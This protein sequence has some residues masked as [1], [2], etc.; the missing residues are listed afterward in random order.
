[1]GDRAP[2]KMNIDPML[3]EVDVQQQPN[4]GMQ[5]TVYEYRWVILILA[6]VVVLLALGIYAYITRDG[7][8]VRR[9]VPPRP[10]QKQP[11]DEKTLM[12]AKAALLKTAETEQEPAVDE[13][14][15]PHTDSREEPENIDQVA[16]ETRAEP[17]TP[18]VDEP[19]P[20]EPEVSAGVKDLPTIAKKC[21]KPKCNKYVKNGDFCPL[22]SGAK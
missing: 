22:H 4:V 2:L 20:A 9:P 10:A 16:V 17:E 18:A 11:P 1:M 15:Q 21:Q 19:K 13:T 5:T 6:L 8:E 12:A 7:S 3:S 14:Q